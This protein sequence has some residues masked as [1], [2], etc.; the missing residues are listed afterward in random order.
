MRSICFATVLGLS[1]AFA[2]IAQDVAQEPKVSSESL[3]KEQVTVYRAVLQDFLKDSTDTLKL[4]NTTEPIEETAGP[5]TRGCPKTSSSAIPDASVLLVHH[6]D[7][8]V[9]LNLKI[10][11]VDPQR[12]EEKIKNGKRW[13]RPKNT[14]SSPGL[15]YSESGLTVIR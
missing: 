5:F 4:A 14:Y 1:L 13:I 8:A 2:A 10:D 11:L 12:Q 3:T 9:A 15:L 7:L 6:I